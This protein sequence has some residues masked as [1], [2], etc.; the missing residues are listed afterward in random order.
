MVLFSPKEAR[1]ISMICFLTL[2]TPTAIKGL[3]QAFFGTLLRLFGQELHHLD[4]S[5]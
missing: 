2:F 1:L 5:Y 4:C 3:V